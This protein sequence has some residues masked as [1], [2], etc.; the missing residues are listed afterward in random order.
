METEA[1]RICWS[2]SPSACPEVGVEQGSWAVKELDSVPK[3]PWGWATLGMQRRPFPSSDLRASCDSALGF[4]LWWMSPYRPRCQFLSSAAPLGFFLPAQLLP[5]IIQTLK[6]FQIFLC[7]SS[8]HLSYLP[9]HEDNC[10]DNPWFICILWAPNPMFEYDHMIVLMWSE[11]SV[12]RTVFFRSRNLT[13]F[14]ACTFVDNMSWCL[15]PTWCLIPSHDP[16]QSGLC[17]LQG[18]FRLGNLMSFLPYPSWNVL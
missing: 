4:E 7:A 16:D 15:V 11:I 14:L 3:V 5:W 12:L 10:I 1:Q 8:H 9:R 18:L 2:L 13:P 17:F 6:S